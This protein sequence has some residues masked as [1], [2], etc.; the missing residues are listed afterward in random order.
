MNTP[1]FYGLK[2]VVRITP[3]CSLSRYSVLEK[4]RLLCCGGV[5][6]VN[7]NMSMM[8]IRMTTYKCGLKQLRK[9][10]TLFCVL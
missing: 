5:V 4:L 3:P 7:K 9:Q 1:L 8:M 2:T 6:T 10:I